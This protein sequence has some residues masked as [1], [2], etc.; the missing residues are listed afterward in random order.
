[1][2]TGPGS[3]SSAPACGKVTTG[4]HCRCRAGS[5]CLCGCKLQ[6]VLVAQAVKWRRRA[7]GHP[8]STVLCI[9]SS[10]GPHSLHFLSLSPP[11][12]SSFHLPLLSLPPSPFS[13]LP[14]SLLPLHLT[15]P[16]FLRPEV[17]SH[18]PGLTSTD[19]CSPSA[20]FLSEPASLSFLGLQVCDL[21]CSR[22]ERPSCEPFVPSG[23]RVC[24][25]Q[26]IKQD[27]PPLGFWEE[28]G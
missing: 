13:F 11:S 21:R 27:S 26:G 3:C 17:A 23:Q 16:A 25:A 19:S 20:R 2:K 28:G 7:A 24:C 5:R 8:G 14:V 1:M 22:R 18:V 10:L 15:L 9:F 6:K 12:L 4:A